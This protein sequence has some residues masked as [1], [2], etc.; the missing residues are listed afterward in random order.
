MQPA[1]TDRYEEAAVYVLLIAR[2]VIARG[3]W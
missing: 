1:E 3:S 2:L